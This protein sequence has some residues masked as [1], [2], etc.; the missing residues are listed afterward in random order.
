MPPPPPPSLT[1]PSPAPA[2]AASQHVGPSIY[3]I[4]YNH[5][6]HHAHQQQGRMQNFPAPQAYMVPYAQQQQQQQ[7]QPGETGSSSSYAPMNV[8]LNTTSPYHTPYHIA[9]MPP[10]ERP[11]QETRIP[12][13]VTEPLLRPKAAARSKSNKKS[14]P[15]RITKPKLAKGAK[16]KQRPQ[17]SKHLTPSLRAAIITLKVTDPNKSFKEIGEI[18]SLPADDEYDDDEEEEEE[19][20]DEDDE[21][22]DDESEANQSIGKNGEAHDLATRNGSLDVNNNMT[23]KTTT[24]PNLETITTNSATSNPTPFAK[25]AKPKP[26]PKERRPIPRNTVAGIFKRAVDRAGT[27]SDLFKLLEQTG[28]RAGSGRPR[29]GTGKK[30]RERPIANE[31]PTTAATAAAAAAAA[32]TIDE[33]WQTDLDGGPVHGNGVNG[34][35]SGLGLEMGLDDE[36]GAID[37]DGLEMDGLDMD[38]DPDG[39]GG[40]DTDDG[41]GGGGGGGGGGGDDR[42]GENGE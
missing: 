4:T 3:Q 42:G 41:D 30:E 21:N 36:D 5:H 37:M 28:R 40:W 25:P 18:L 1:P 39:Q 26:K 6:N 24:D 23:N 19:E 33:T 27:E 7:Q 16:A 15:M 13:I 32:A 20:D 31:M 12:Q 35:A 10:E 14:P 29:K 9:P 38:G 8:H 17:S 11:P 34:G 2:T 22:A